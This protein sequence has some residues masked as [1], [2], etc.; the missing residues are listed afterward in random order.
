MDK[1]HISAYGHYLC[2][3]FHLPQLPERGY[4][5]DSRAVNSVRFVIILPQLGILTDFTE[6]SIVLQHVSGLD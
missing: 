6:L 5:F 3:S 4:I 2:A 1:M